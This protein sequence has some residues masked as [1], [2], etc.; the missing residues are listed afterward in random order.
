MLIVTEPEEHIT[1]DNTTGFQ[2]QPFSPDTQPLTILRFILRVIIVVGKVL[3]KIG[4][5]TRPILLG[6]AAKYK[7]TA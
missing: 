2:S 7:S 6:Y 5:R 3:V 4:L 1:R